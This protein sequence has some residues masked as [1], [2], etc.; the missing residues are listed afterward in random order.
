MSKKKSFIKWVVYFLTIS[1]FDQFIEWLLRLYLY[2]M[3]KRCIEKTILKCMKYK[4]DQDDIETIRTVAEK[5]IRRVYRFVDKSI[6]SDRVV[7]GKYTFFA[8]AIVATLVVVLLHE[9]AA[10]KLVTLTT[11]L[12]LAMAASFGSTRRSH[13][14]D[15]SIFN[16]S[17][18]RSFK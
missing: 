8:T 1:F 13:T 18:G 11:Q 7:R 15:R 4:S 6:L 14:N 17:S 3:Q 16:W 5:E 9:V 2:R 12:V 10:I